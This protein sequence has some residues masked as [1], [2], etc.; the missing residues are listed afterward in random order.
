MD[1]GGSR[2]HLTSALKWLLL[3]SLPYVGHKTINYYSLSSHHVFVTV[4]FGFRGVNKFY[5]Y[6]LSFMNRASDS[7]G[8][9]GVVRAS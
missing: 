7:T 1:E 8:I 4:K 9:S 2:G 5:N 6:L 3:C